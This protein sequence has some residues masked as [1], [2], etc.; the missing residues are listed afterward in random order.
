MK[1]DHEVSRL[2]CVL[3]EALRPDH[4][5]HLLAIIENEGMEKVLDPELF[6]AARYFDRRTLLTFLA[7]LGFENTKEQAHYQRWLA[8]TQYRNGQIDAGEAARLCASERPLMVDFYR[9]L[10][11]TLDNPKAEATWLDW[12]EMPCTV[13]D[14]LFATEFLL[15]CQVVQWLPF[16][17]HRWCQLDNSGE[18]WL[19]MYRNVIERVEYAQTV[20]Q[21]QVLAQALYMLLKKVA[22]E[23]QSMMNTLTAKL[24]DLYLRAEQSDQALALAQTLLSNS[25][26]LSGTYWLM[27]SHANRSQFSE[28][29]KFASNF[30]SAVIDKA[31]KEKM[32]EDLLFKAQEQPKKKKDFDV[33]A[34]NKSLKTVNRILRDRGLQ[35]F[36]MSGVLLG[37][38]REGQILPHDKDIDLGLIGWEQQFEVAQALLASGRY[39]VSW[40]NLRGAKT[41]LLDAYDMENGVAVDFFFFHPHSDHFL[42]GI[43]YKYGFT[44]NFRFSPFGLKEIDFLGERFFIPDNAEKNLVEN[45]GDWKTP[46][47]SYVVTVEAPVLVQKGSEKHQFIA[48]IELMRSVET[49]NSVKRVQRIL[50]CC[51]AL[52]M[53]VLSTEL[54]HRLN[55]W[56]VRQALH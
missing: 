50:D 25:S 53:H 30:L 17:L 4:Q 43:D 8:A 23:H 18:P 40:R 31:I 41:F 26:D 33:N 49:F 6:K 14:M 34:A 52:D 16:V 27:R 3:Q 29:I 11:K 54:E 51:N 35:P 32:S 55:D 5:K 21:S 19:W 45:Y 20:Q 13:A 39:H 2:M 22:P 44:Q 7:S 12:M 48:L 10:L 46:Q 37:Y 24:V 1:F 9:N 28:A 38:M 42:H 56:M 47:S 36:L 15:D